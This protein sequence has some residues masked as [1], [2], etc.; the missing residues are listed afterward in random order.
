[1]NRRT[2][3]IIQTIALV[4]GLISIAVGVALSHWAATIAGS[5]CAFVAII[6]LVFSGGCEE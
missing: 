3:I 1:M 5:I 4:I 2:S 6:G